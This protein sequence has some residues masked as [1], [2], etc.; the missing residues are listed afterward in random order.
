MI[1]VSF[2][3]GVFCVIEKKEAEILRVFARNV[4]VFCSDES[5]GRGSL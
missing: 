1:K 5:F 4:F 3:Q 2:T